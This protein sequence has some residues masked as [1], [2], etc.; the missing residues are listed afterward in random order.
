M[1]FVGRVAALSLHS[2]G[3]LPP[4]PATSLRAEAV[5]DG[6]VPAARSPGQG[7]AVPL[8]VQPLSVPG[9]IFCPSCLLTLEALPRDCAPVSRRIRSRGPPRRFPGPSRAQRGREQ[10]PPMTGSC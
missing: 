2:P 10:L 1:G 6:L 9:G 3:A 5:G 8:G 4:A 7:R